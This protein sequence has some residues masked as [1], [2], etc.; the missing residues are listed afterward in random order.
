MT[1]QR[2]WPDRDLDDI[3]VIH[4]APSDKHAPRFERGLPCCLGLNRG[5][6]FWS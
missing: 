5:N 6:G 4:I 3:G 1:C 2:S